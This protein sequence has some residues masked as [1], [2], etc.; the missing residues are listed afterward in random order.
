MGG[1]WAGTTSPSPAQHL[2]PINK[3]CSSNWRNLGASAE[4]GGTA[5]AKKESYGGGGS[6]GMEGVSSLASLVRQWCLGQGMGCSL[7]EIG[8]HN[9]V[10]GQGHQRNKE[11]MRKYYLVCL[12]NEGI[13]EGP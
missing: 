6:K 4:S 2:Y 11:I 9:G 5:M 3:G 13:C 7:G 1:G 8:L 12:H 10:G